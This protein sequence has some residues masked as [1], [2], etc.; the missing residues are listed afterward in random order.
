[1][2][3]KDLEPITLTTPFLTQRARLSEIA[4]CRRR[5]AATVTNQ[6]AAA[7]EK[8]AAAQIFDETATVCSGNDAH[9]TL[10]GAGGQ[11][12]IG[13]QRCAERP[14]PPQSLPGVAAFG[15]HFGAAARQFLLGDVEP[16]QAQ[17]YVD[18]DAVAVFDQADQAAL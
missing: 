17:G 2:A 10:G 6:D 9:R 18:L 5:R 8:G 1:D 13:A 11:G 4:L 12:G 3:G 14:H 15:L 16:H 7:P